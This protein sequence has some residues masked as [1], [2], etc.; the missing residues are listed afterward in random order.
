MNNKSISV[1]SSFI[2]YG[3]KDEIWEVIVFKDVTSEKLDAVCK[4]AGAMAHEM[5][6]PLQILTSCLTLI[7]DKIPGDAELKENY[8]AMRVSCMMMNSIIEK[9]NNLT[10]YKTKHYI[11]KMRILDIE[12]SSDDSGD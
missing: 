6:Q 10:R 9:I 3:D 4:I 12:E 8:T 2:E 5:R 11:Q 7:N 1:L